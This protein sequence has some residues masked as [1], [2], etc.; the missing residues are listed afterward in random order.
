MPCSV[1]VEAASP[2]VADVIETT[3]ACV[4]PGVAVAA[5]VNLLAP[6]EPDE[7]AEHTDRLLHAGADELQCYH[8]GLANRTQLPL[9][10]ALAGGSRLAGG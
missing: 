9:F 8:F 4:S 1:P 3:R 6:V 2:N 7:A 5:Y 10:S